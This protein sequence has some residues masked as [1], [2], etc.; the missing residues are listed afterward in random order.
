M[1]SSERPI[2]PGSGRIA[3]AARAGIFPRSPALVA[4]VVLLTAAGVSFLIGEQLLFSFQAFIKTGLFAALKSRPDP[5]AFAMEFVIHVLLSVGGFFGILF[6]AGLIAA[7]TPAILTRLKRGRTAIELPKAPVDAV[8]RTV[9]SAAGVILFALVAL[10][11]IRT[12]LGSVYDFASGIPGSGIDVFAGACELVASGGAILVLMGIGELV[13]RRTSI[14]HVLSLNTSEAR[15]EAR[16]ANGDP[17][18]KSARRR[19]ARNDGAA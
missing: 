9:F 6:V 2:P 12:H 17:A 16:A 19:N 3:Q 14:I 4:G 8:A 15:R 10:R 1:W 11:I 13:L 5:G 18:L 7:C